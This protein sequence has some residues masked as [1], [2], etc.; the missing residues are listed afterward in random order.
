[1]SGLT[2]NVENGTPQN[3]FGGI[4][5]IDFDPQSG[6]YWV[7]S[8]RGPA[9]GAVAWPIRAHRIELSVETNG[10]A[11]VNGTIVE[12]VFLKDFNRIT[13]T[14]KADV[15]NQVA[16]GPTRFDPEGVRVVGSNLIISDEYG[17][18]VKY[19]NFQGEQL[20]EIEVPSAFQVQH[21]YG[22]EKDEI[23]KNETGR[24]TNRGLEGLA[25]SGNR[26][27]ALLQSPLIQDSRRLDNGKLE[28]LNC[29]L[30]SYDQKNHPA[31]QWVYHLDQTSNKLNEILAIDDT[32]F[33]VI[34]RDGKLGA[35][36][37]FKKIMLVETKG[38]TD[39]S[40]IEKLP[41]DEL[42]ENIQPVKKTTFIDLLDKR[43][44]LAGDSF[45]EK[46]EGLC[47]GPDQADGRKTLIVAVDND[48]ETEH[49]TMIYV[50]AVKL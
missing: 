20:A 50:F 39:V 11:T 13:F 33:L 40:A 2:G 19:F 17:P 8:D 37:E 43:F 35:E 1:M 6:S 25:V 38:A 5:A 32:R 10:A 22:D 4:S 31:L 28:G 27:F 29:R 48:F 3:Q 9:D 14:G 16:A 45:P 44:G 34:E 49:D 46:V 21:P 42:P 30:L 7:V 41:V 12:T 36:A 15:V 26:L 18:Y 47:W 24:M 23:A